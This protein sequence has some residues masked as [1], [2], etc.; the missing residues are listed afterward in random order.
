MN[1]QQKKIK[2]AKFYALTAFFLVTIAFSYLAFSFWKVNYIDKANYSWKNTEEKLSIIT[3]TVS[4]GFLFYGSFLML[5]DY[6][7]EQ[8]EDY[9]S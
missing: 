9:R 5:S 3:L 6:L 8:E 7:S 1:K 4:V 2:K